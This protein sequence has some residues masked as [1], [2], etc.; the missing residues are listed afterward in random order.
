[1]V[2]GLMVALV[3][4]AL[5]QGA[6]AG[7]GAAWLK[8]VPADVDLVARVR[9]AE[10]TRDDLV[11][12]LQATS[13]QLAAQACPPIED[14]YNQF[15]G[16]YGK[17]ATKAPLLFLFKL[18]KPDAIG[19]PPFAFL[20]KNDDYAAIQ[21]QL[22][23]PMGNPRPKSNP[24]GF[25]ELKGSD[26]L[27]VYTFKGPGFVAF[28][29]N[30]ALMAQIAKPKASLEDSLSES[31]RK[32]LLSGDMG[33][34]VNVATFQERYKDEIDQMR[35]QVLAGVDNGPAGAANADMMKS[36]K[37]MYA[38]VF[39]ALKDGQSLV[40]S[41]DF[42]PAGLDLSGEVST[43]P[44]STTSK[45]LTGPEPGPAD[46]LAKLPTGLTNYLFFQGSQS[47]AEQL[48]SMGLTAFGPPGGNASAAY[49]K[50]L[51]LQQ[52][53]GVRTIASASNMGPK[54]ME[55]AA[56]TVY[57]DP[58]KAVEA[59]TAILQAST[60][61]GSQLKSMIK[62][63]SIEPKAETYNGLV[64][65]RSKIT[66]DPQKLA[67]LQPGVPNAGNMLQAMFKEPMTTWYGVDGKAVVSVM[68]P[69]WDRAKL[70]LDSLRGGEANLG[71]T[72]SFRAIR[73]KLPAQTNG[74]LLMSSQ[75]LVSQITTSLTNMAGGQAGAIPPP[76]DLPKE[77]VFLGGSFIT[78]PG[79]LEFQTI[80]PATAGGIFEKGLGPVLNG[81]Q[82]RVNQ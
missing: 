66:W 59:M 81:I 44:G 34:Y 67:Q 11:K 65:N 75:G 3:A 7:E 71:S 20:I 82:G 70:M 72:P 29:N 26:G 38:S 18:P 61:P 56:T 80:V 79:I 62:D 42:A 36:A 60:A 2:S 24:A 31:L 73:S 22:V 16:R 58:Q 17:D 47:A 9:G 64:L 28:S 30:D 37:Q 74:I 50:A 21:K 78:H 15:V 23:G 39:D 54:G 14:V 5:G 69:T 48:L 1:M 45:L 4:A 6:A 41:F 51:E 8:A 55:A 40:L 43:K 76:G 77:P 52:Q 13:A 33:V 53:A 32:R 25:D 27:P 12:M 46:E 63:I 19:T 10:A 68:A 57:D 49:K 35:Q